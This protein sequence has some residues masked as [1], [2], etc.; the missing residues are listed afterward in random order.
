M[1]KLEI[2]NS[3]LESLKKAESLFDIE[4]KY[5]KDPPKKGEENYILG[6][7]GV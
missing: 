6:L 3:F 4:K 5:Y 7:R 1:L 2:S